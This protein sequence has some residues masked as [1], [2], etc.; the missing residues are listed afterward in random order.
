MMID[1]NQ[2]LSPAA[3]LRA[4]YSLKV[5]RDLLTKPIVSE[6]TYLSASLKENK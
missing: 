1:I 2:M 4:S 5:L 6:T 3:C